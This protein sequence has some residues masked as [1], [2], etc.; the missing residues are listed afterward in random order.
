[1][2]SKPKCLERFRCFS[3][4]RVSETIAADSLNHR[5][6]AYFIVLLMPKIGIDLVA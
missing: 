1:M 5:T 4:A 3:Y 2:P 6:H